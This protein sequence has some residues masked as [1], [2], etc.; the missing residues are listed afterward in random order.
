ML[1]NHPARMSTFIALLVFNAP[2][3]NAG[4][5]DE[6]SDAEAP[7]FVTPSRMSSSY[8]ET[9]NSVTRL[10]AEDLYYLGITNVTDALRLVPGMLITEIE[11]G[12][13][14]V[15]YHGSNVNVPRRMEVLY[16]SNSIYRPGY[17][18]IQWLS[19]P[20]DVN[21][22]TAIEVVRGSNVV[23]FGSNAFSG[24]V[25]LIPS[26][27]VL[28]PDFSMEVLSGSGEQ[29]KIWLSNHFSIGRG[30]YIF[31]YSHKENGGFDSL[32]DGTEIDDFT[33]GDN[34]LLASEVELGD[35]H[36]FDLTL[37]V[38]QYS[39]VPSR[40]E[41]LFD[42]ADDDLKFIIDG[43]STPEAEESSTS[44][45]A[46]YSGTGMLNGDK[47]SWFLSGNYVKYKRVQDIDLCLRSFFF[48][49]LLA[50]LDASPNVHL[51]R[52]D[53]PL[54]LTSSL[55]AGVAELDQSIVS[56]L[57]ESDLELL[58]LIGQRMFDIGPIELLK[59]KCGTS[60]IS[61]E[62]ERYGIEGGFALE[63]KNKYALSTNI[64]ISKSIATSLHYLNGTVDRT[65]ISLSS[66]FRY[67]I[68]DR[69]VLNF[70]A[71]FETNNRIDD[72]Y[73]SGRASLNWEMNPSHIFRMT[74]SHSE[75]SPDIHE[76]DRDWNYYMVFDEGVTDHLGNSSAYLP[77][78]AKSPDA[79]E[80][81]KIDSF[82]LAYV[83]SKE[84]HTFDIKY[85]QEHMYDLISEPFLYMDFNL[86]NNGELDLE[87]SEFS[88]AYKSRAYSGLKGGLS[89]LNLHNNTNS[90]Y[91]KT[92]YAKNTA[93]LFTIIPL[94]NHYTLGATLYY[95]ENIAGHD[96]NRIDFNL[97][98]SNILNDA[99]IKFRLNYRYYP[100]EIYSFTEVSSTESIGSKYDNRNRFYLSLLIEF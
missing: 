91:E 66:N 9:P 64:N 14:I 17:S 19:L 47:A 12:D 67:H 6:F 77:R 51:V 100:E 61:L 46:K 75:R 25:N 13:P 79:L 70:G 16:N 56:P 59:R 73:P 43:A 62:E 90:D 23:D 28:E 5:F 42:D 37:T 76:L 1:G 60:D 78:N 33:R 86:T 26:Q 36:I 38:N 65:S 68:I 87:G 30:E 54:V 92:L 89:Y 41:T 53:I 99:D 81:E 8:A 20:V 58:R 15:G 69:L 94:S 22:L 98:Y 93:T 34:F 96:Y 29:K 18:S 39:Y 97:A 10:E 71:H 63:Q 52:E 88:Y 32:V 57:S 85:F 55:N 4:M 82:D 21:D 31:K 44:F 40:L 48:D 74:A 35:G 45:V 2:I 11:S 7:L 83:Y 80:S 3:T 72:V 24:T 84:A 95:F 27:A 49:P 50:Q